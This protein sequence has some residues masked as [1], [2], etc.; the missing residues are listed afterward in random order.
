[1]TIK[2]G[3]RGAEVEEARRREKRAREEVELI[4]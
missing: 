2:L 1:M 4:R 3:E